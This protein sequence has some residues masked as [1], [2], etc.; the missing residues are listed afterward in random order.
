MFS[1]NAQGTTI[2]SVAEMKKKLSEIKKE[3]QNHQDH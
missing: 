2:R 1:V 3:G